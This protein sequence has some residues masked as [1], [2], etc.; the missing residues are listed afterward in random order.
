MFL[1]MEFES[2]QIVGENFLG[3]FVSTKDRDQHGVM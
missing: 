1:F 2:H 3:L